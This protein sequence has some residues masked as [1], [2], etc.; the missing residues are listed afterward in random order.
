MRIRTKTN[1][2]NQYIIASLYSKARATILTGFE[3]TALFS[4]KKI[5]CSQVSNGNKNKPDH[6]SFLQN[7]FKKLLHLNPDSCKN[8]L[9]QL[10]LTTNKGKNPKFLIFQVF[11]DSAHQ[12][13]IE[14]YQGHI[15]LDEKIRSTAHTDA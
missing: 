6:E 7:N 1:R 11:R 5:F 9:K 12:A 3:F 2:N 10:K 8:E 4:E 13:E 15:K 14:R